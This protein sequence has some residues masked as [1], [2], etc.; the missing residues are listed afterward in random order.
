MKS[1]KCLNCGANVDIK[2]QTCQYCGSTY[3]QPTEAQ[4]KQSSS[5]TTLGAFLNDISK[6]LKPLD[7]MIK[8]IY[9]DISNGIKKG[10]N[11]TKQPTIKK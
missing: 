1:N 8:P 2:T 6:A 10:I 11:E 5:G 9:D 7:D 3:A 4:T